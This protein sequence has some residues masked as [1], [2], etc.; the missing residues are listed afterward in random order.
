[1]PPPKQERKCIEEMAKA[2]YLLR[3]SRTPNV[4]I[5]PWEELNGF[6]RHVFMQHAEENYAMLRAYEENT[7]GRPTSKKRNGLR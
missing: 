6:S 2:L 4:E 5:A 7:A 1:M 3:C